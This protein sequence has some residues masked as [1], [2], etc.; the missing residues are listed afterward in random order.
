MI[1][2]INTGFDRLKQ[3]HVDSG[4][5]GGTIQVIMQSNFIFTVVN[6]IGIWLIVYNDYLS[7]YIPLYIGVLIGLF[8]VPMWWLFYYSVV[9]PSLIQ[10]SNRQ[11]WKHSSPVKKEFEVLNERLNKIEKLLEEKF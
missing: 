7:K 5:I 2:D 8:A 4:Q 11:A 1:L 6:S 9:Q 10:Y 3:F